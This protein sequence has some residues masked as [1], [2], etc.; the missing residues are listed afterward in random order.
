MRVVAMVM[1]EDLHDENQVNGN[2][3]GV[4]TSSPRQ[5]GDRGYR[6]S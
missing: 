6:F 5:I 3:D 2:L 4:S 1:V